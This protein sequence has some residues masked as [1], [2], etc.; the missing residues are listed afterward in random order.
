M[1]ETSVELNAIQPASNQ[2]ETLIVATLVHTSKFSNL[3]IESWT[4]KLN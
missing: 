1:K 3:L 2:K 4:K